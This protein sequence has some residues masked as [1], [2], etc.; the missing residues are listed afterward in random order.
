VTQARSEVAENSQRGNWMKVLRIVGAIAAVGLLALV[1]WHIGPRAIARQLLAAGPGFIWI[2]ALHAL[3]IAIAALPWHVLLPRDARPTI[4]QSVASRFVAAGA[5][6]VTPIVSFAG[7]LVRLFWLPRKADRPH[8]VAAIVADRLTYGAANLTFVVAGAIALVHVSDLPPEYTRMTLIGGIVLMVLVALCAVLAARFRLVGRI[9]HLVSR[10]RRKERDHQFGDDV[11]ASIEDMLRRQP[12]RLALA[13]VFNVL[14]RLAMSLQIYIAFRLL[15]VQLAW[16]EALVFAAL[17]IVMAI[18]GF[19]V[20]SQVGV[21]E[22]AQALLAD[23]F[24]IPSTTAVAVVLLLRIRSI[25]GGALVALLIATKR[26]TITAQ[27]AADDAAA[28]DPHAANG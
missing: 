18:A 5:N 1:I 15:G 26:S 11:D 21:Q 23:S 20:P 24:G 10:L 14:F 16:D 6:A 8:G 27:A 22:G 3:A 19:M 12:G 25:V 4:W 13:F 9:H 7:D 17:P 2:V 28:I